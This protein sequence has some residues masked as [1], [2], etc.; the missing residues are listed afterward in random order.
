MKET[1]TSATKTSQIDLRYQ[2]YQ[3]GN[4]TS[5]WCEVRPYS[6]ASPGTQLFFDSNDLATCNGLVMS[7]VGSNVYGTLLPYVSG[8]KYTILVTR[9]SDGSTTVYTTRA[10]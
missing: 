5:A 8:G 9:P 10:P 3:A 1:S 7:N 6:K 2:V 4:S